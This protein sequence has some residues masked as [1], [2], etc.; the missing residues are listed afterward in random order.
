[1]VR[2]SLAGNMLSSMSPLPTRGYVSA[3]SLPEIP[4]DGQFPFT[5]VRWLDLSDNPALYGLPVTFAYLPELRKIKTRRTGLA[6]RA[7]RVTDDS[8]HE[9]IANNP[10]GRHDNFLSAPRHGTRA[11]V[12][13]CVVAIVRLLRA[14]TPEEQPGGLRETPDPYPGT[15]HMSTDTSGKTPPSTFGRVLD[16]SDHGV[17][18]L[19]LRELLDDTWICD[20]CGKPVVPLVHPIKHD[21]MP[22]RAVLHLRL[23]QGKEVRLEGRVCR[24]CLSPLKR[25]LSGADNPL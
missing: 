8:A 7:P 2:V 3:D 11:L 5:R 25:R 21:P 19:R 23:A 17:E 20:V 6:D 13:L 15:P 18:T 22:G 1:M 16:A 12:E 10:A 24:K 4:G 14:S 9:H